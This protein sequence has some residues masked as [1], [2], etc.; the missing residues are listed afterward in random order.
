V[1]RFKLHVRDDDRVITAKGDVRWVPG[2]SPW[3]WL[4][5][6]AVTAIALVLLARTRFAVPVLVVALAAVFV[7]EIVHVVGAWDAT[8]LGVGTRLGASVY[9]LGAAAVSVVAL[10]WVLR[11]GVHAAA[12]LLLVAGLFVGIAGGLTDL[13][14]LTRSQLP[15]TL[16]LAVARACVALALGLGIGLAVTGGLRLRGSAEERRQRHLHRR[17]TPRASSATTSVAS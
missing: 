2:P 16:P 15:T 6:A 9:A 7:I 12:P 3:P 10:V 8:T 1:Q 4:A 11:R 5:L 14:E 13:T 17:G